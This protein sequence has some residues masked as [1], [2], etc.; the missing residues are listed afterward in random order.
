MKTFVKNFAL[1]LSLFAMTATTVIAQQPTIN[2]FRPYDKAGI[3][4]FESPKDKLAKFD[5]LK[6]RFGAGFT[7]QYQC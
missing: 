6:I 5:G 1:G 2:N 4:V 7:Q 3:G